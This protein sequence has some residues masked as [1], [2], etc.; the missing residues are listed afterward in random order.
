MGVLIFPSKNFVVWQNSV[1]VVTDAINWVDL[2][3]TEHQQ[4]LLTG[5][6]HQPF[7]TDAHR[8]YVNG[9]RVKWTSF[10]NTPMFEVRVEP[11]G[12]P[13]SGVHRTIAHVIDRV[14][15]QEWTPPLNAVDRETHRK[16]WAR[17]QEQQEE[18]VQFPEHCLHYGEHDPLPVGDWVPTVFHQDT[19]EAMYQ[20]SMDHVQPY[21]DPVH[22]F[23]YRV[24]GPDLNAEQVASLCILW[25][26]AST[27][28]EA[29]F[30]AKW[31]QLF[32]PM[33]SLNLR[34]VLGI[35]PLLKP[36]PTFQLEDGKLNILIAPV[37][38]LSF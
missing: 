7:H 5:P 18:E 17:L 36:L 38:Q 23:F 13:R 21:M 1:D 11:V 26:I 29:F 22:Q 3:W 16:V 4:H 27:C 24:Y 34:H 6:D 8:D 20:K 32:S 31:I 10:L 2:D 33:N 12:V 28:E 25:H 35:I 30:L 37:L 14:Q 9:I 15:A 19:G